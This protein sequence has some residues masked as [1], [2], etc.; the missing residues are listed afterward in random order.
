MNYGVFVWFSVYRAETTTPSP[1]PAAAAAAV[2]RTHT[3][4]IRETFNCFL[5]IRR[6]EDRVKTCTN[7][8]NAAEYI[9]TRCV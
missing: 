7:C 1:P 2:L 8:G 9:K 4:S 6:D 5:H 3:R